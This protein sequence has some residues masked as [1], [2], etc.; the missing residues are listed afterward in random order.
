V[1]G[2]GFAGY[3]FITRGPVKNLDSINLYFP[4]VFSEKIDPRS[5]FTV[6]DQ[7]LAEHLFGFHAHISPKAGFE[8]YTSEVRF[9]PGRS[10]VSVHPKFELRRGDGSYLAFKQLCV[11]LESSLRGT[12]HAPYHGILDGIDCDESTRKAVIKFK[13]IPVNLRFLFTLPDF[14]I[15]DPIDLPLSAHNGI[16]STGPYTLEGLSRDHASL[17]RNPFYPKELMS[18][19]V[20]HIEISRYSA[21]DSEV[22][23]NQMTPESH[24]AAYFF[25]YSLTNDDLNK[26]RNKG[27][28]V[29]ISPTEWFVYF[30]LKKGVHPDIRAA[31]AGVTEQFK[32]SAE[33][34]SSLG[35][36]ATSIAPSD[37]EY[38]LSPD[39]LKKILETKFQATTIKRLPAVKVATLETWAGIPFFAKALNYL[40]KELPN[41]TVELLPPAQIGKLFSDEIQI[42]LCPLGISPT[43]PLS[44]FSFL[45]NTFA[46]FKSIISLEEIAEVATITDPT[47]FNHRVQ[48]FERRTIASG[49]LLPLGHFPGVV[50]MRSDFKVNESQSFGWGIQAWSIRQD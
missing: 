41:V 36:A 50:A 11:G 24:H 16:R 23:V 43:D 28:S 6:G 15:F 2:L 5:I 14:A 33:F 7:V 19:D 49:F 30:S 20:D 12:Q 10:E 1:V 25:G 34:H 17:K 31:L 47:E 40:K 27:Y 4:F 29:S 18:N 37:R 38:A 42:A 46:G 9:L 45:A 39:D 8:D 13:T 35:V 48:D 32:A 26:L 3:R 44:H 22:L 21:G